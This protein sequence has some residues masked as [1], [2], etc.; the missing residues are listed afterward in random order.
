MWRTR[1]IP[2]AAF[3]IAASL[4]GPA[5]A[6]DRDA[7]MGPFVEGALGDLKLDV[8]DS[9]SRGVPGETALTPALRELTIS[10]AGDPGKLL[11]F[12]P[13]VTL[14]GA[15]VNFGGAYGTISPFPSGDIGTARL[16]GGVDFGSL[17]FGASYDHSSGALLADTGARQRG[18]DLGAARRAGDIGHLAPA[19]P[20]P[21]HAGGK[22][23][24]GGPAVDEALE[25]AGE[26]AV[27]QVHDAGRA[28][29]TPGNGSVARDE[30][31]AQRARPPVDGDDRPH[32]CPSP[33]QEQR[34]VPAV[35]LIIMRN[36][37]W[38][39]LP[40]FRRVRRASRWP[41]LA[42]WFGLGF[43]LGAAGTA[44]F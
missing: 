38:D 31:G 25:R 44:L 4:A 42:A 19:L 36:T 8:G 30:S 27:R 11:Y 7:R 23:G 9:L 15:T 39:E 24:E 21:D 16:G 22:D 28:L 18:F 5:G 6:L 34:L 14:G 13:S 3:V 12:T 37:E 29:G 26:V 2:L 17:R 40:S 33:A 20:A 10:P 32:L 43:L 41:R 35:S 1:L